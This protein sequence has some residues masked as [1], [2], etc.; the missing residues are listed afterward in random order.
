MNTNTY[1]ANTSLNYAY[2]EKGDAEEDQKRD[3]WMICLRT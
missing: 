3:G 1:Y 2:N